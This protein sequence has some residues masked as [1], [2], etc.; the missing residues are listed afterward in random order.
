MI[1]KQ[2]KKWTT[3]DGTKIRICDMSDNHLKNTIN[4]LQHNFDSY[5]ERAIV[6]GYN[7]LTTIQGEM[8]EFEIDNELNRLENGFY[9][10]EDEI[11]I[12]N[13]LILDLERREENEYENIK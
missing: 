8:A 3:K 11:S 5:I 7:I 13:N 10:I 2:T 12:Y 9:C 4:L 1:R 6:N